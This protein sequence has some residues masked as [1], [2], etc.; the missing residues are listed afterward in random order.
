MFRRIRIAILLSILA[1]VALNTWTDSL[2]T[3]K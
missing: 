2:Y 1:I 3:T